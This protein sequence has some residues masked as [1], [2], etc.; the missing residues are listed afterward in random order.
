MQLFSQFLCLCLLAATVWWGY[1]GQDNLVCVSGDKQNTCKWE[2]C[3]IL[4]ANINQRGRLMEE[5]RHAARNSHENTKS[6][7]MV[8]LVLKFLNYEISYLYLC[9][10]L[11]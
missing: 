8:C 5:C 10:V 3:L 11:G 7:L 9:S 4:L 6:D 2:S 1:L